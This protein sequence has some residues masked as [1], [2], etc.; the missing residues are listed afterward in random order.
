[1]IHLPKPVAF[2]CRIC[3]AP[4]FEGELKSY[5]AHVSKCF[6]RNEQELRERSLAHRLP[7]LYGPEA[8]DPEYEAWVQK[9]GRS[10]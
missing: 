4:F 2:A 9:T 10:H 6:D 3:K 8:G 5:E 7:G 1:M